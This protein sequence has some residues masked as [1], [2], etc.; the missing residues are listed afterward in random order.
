MPAF[1]VG[2]RQFCVFSN[3]HHGDGR[4][5]IVCAAAEGAQAMFVDSDP[6]VYYVPP[7]VGVAGWI[8]VR[9][10]KRL[11]WSQVAAV[12]EAAHAH[13]AAKQASPASLRPGTARTRRRR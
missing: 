9:L 1:F 2:K 10:D 6:G 3:D 7:Y 8:G 12:I 5:A 13:V 11:A 4:L